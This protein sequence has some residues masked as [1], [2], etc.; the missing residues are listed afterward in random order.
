MSPLH[1]YAYQYTSNKIQTSRDIRKQHLTVTP[2][3]AST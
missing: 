1:C 2:H 3:N